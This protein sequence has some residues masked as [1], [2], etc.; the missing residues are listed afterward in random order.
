[1]SAHQQQPSTIFCYCNIHTCKEKSLV[2]RA[3]VRCYLILLCV[4][5]LAMVRCVA[6][7]FTY[8][9]SF[10]AAKLRRLPWWLRKEWIMQPRPLYIILSILSIYTHH[11][12]V[13]TMA[14]WFCFAFRWI[15]LCFCL[16]RVMQLQMLLLY[17]ES[18]IWRVFHEKANTPSKPKVSEPQRPCNAWMCICVWL[19]RFQA[20][21]RANMLEVFIISS[22]WGRLNE[23]VILNLGSAPARQESIAA[24]SNPTCSLFA[25]NK[26]KRLCL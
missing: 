22:I 25:L 11:T 5:R 26:R 18:E 14:L 19:T 8:L 17:T 4:W 16:Y 3:R 13:N 1:M 9:Y 23:C 20:V 15:R 10:R 21:I 12:R 6:H 2:A 7:I 24:V